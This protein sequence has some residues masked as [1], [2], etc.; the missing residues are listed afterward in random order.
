MEVA[1]S[2]RHWFDWGIRPSWLR[3][4]SA[5]KIVLYNDLLHIISS[6]VLESPSLMWSWGWCWGAGPPCITRAL[7]V[8]LGR[9]RLTGGVF[10]TCNPTGSA[11]RCCG[12]RSNRCCRLFD[13]V[14]LIMRWTLTACSLSNTPLSIHAGLGPYLWHSKSREVQARHEG[15]LSSHFFLRSRQVQQPNWLLPARMTRM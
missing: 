14:W 3:K 7:W 12:V 1:V 8:G 15:R 9:L 2:N 6:K 13:L 11:L 10:P 4:D 5:R